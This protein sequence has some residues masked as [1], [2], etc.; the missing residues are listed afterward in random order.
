MTFRGV[1]VYDLLEPLLKDFR[2]LRIRS[3]GTPSSHSKE[4]DTD[5]LYSGSH[6]DVHG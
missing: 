1:E 5:E 6:T 2:K 4:S 3:M